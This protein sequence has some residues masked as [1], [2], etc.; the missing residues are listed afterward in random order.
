MDSIFLKRRALS[1]WEDAQHHHSRGELDRAIDLYTR[2]IAIFPTAEAYTYRGWAYSTQ[3]RW[4]DA[5]LECKKAIE[6]DPDLG[7][8][9][10]DIGS[11]L[12]SLGKLD[13]CVEWL[14]KAKAAAR[15][16]PRH[17]PYMNLGKVYLSQG[18]IIRAIR[19][20]E[21]ALKISPGEPTCQ[22]L[23][24]ELKRTLH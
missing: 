20:F 1:I 9:Y 17:Y 19:E 11:Y 2:S 16:E 13:E 8:P 14:E 12:I 4:E 15:Y 7:N 10:N 21:A 6:I 22:A 5:I 18:M 23:L 3:Q 24:S